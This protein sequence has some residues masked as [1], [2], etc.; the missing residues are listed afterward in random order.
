MRPI[1]ESARSWPKDGMARDG[2]MKDD[3]MKKGEMKGD[4]TMER[5]P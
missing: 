5:K 3:A 1:I 2:M 4:A